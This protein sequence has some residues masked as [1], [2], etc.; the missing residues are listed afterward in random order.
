M[1]RQQT[2]QKKNAARNDGEIHHVKPRDKKMSSGGDNAGLLVWKRKSENRGG[3]ATVSDAAVRVGPLQRNQILN[4]PCRTH[5][6][7]QV[8]SSPYMLFSHGVMCFG[9]HGRI[10]SLVGCHPFPRVANALYAKGRSRLATELWTEL[11]AFWITW[12]YLRREVSTYR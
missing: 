3:G 6:D 10:L 9:P 7:Y 1:R 2:H 8:P 5:R 4:P 12:L 11:T